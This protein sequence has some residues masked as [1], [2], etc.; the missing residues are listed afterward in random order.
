MS[1][2]VDSNDDVGSSCGGSFDPDS[3]D[4]PVLTPMRPILHI[5]TRQTFLDS[6]DSQ[7]AFTDDCPPTPTVEREFVWSPVKPFKLE[8]QDNMNGGETCGKRPFPDV[9]EEECTASSAKNT[10]ADS[11]VSNPEPNE[12]ETLLE[13]EAAD[14][15][16]GVGQ[17]VQSMVKDD[18]VTGVPYAVQ[19]ETQKEAEEANKEPLTADEETEKQAA[20]EPLTDVLFKKTLQY[21][22]ELNGEDDAVKDVMQ[23]II[24]KKSFVKTIYEKSKSTESTDELFWRAAKLLTV[25]GAHSIELG[26][27]KGNIT[28]QQLTPVQFGGIKG[29]VVSTCS[30]YYQTIGEYGERWVGDQIK[31]ENIP[32]EAP[33]KICKMSFPVSSTT[34]DY[35]FLTGQNDCPEDAPIR[36]EQGAIV[37]VGEVKTSAMNPSTRPIWMYEDVT[38][39]EIMNEK[40]AMIRTLFR[41]RQDEKNVKLTPA[42]MPMKLRDHGD[43]C[44]RIAAHAEESTRWSMWYYDDPEN[45]SVGRVEV[46]FDHKNPGNDGCIKLFSSS[47][48]RQMLCE[49]MSVLD[50]VDK[51]AKELEIRAF[52]PSVIDKNPPNPPK[53]R[54][55]KY[56][57]DNEDSTE[58]ADDE[59]EEEE[60]TD[61]PY[62]LTAFS[63]NCTMKVPIAD[64]RELDR[65]TNLYLAEAMYSVAKSRYLM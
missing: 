41:W 15:N 62:L 38:V 53:K 43:L 5:P 34:P 28:K 30:A 46:A 13:K 32:C 56:S 65:V 44:L 51:E 49:A 33:G 9:E 36:F 45:E 3:I 39:R 23:T 54:A 48:G 7:P 60:D 31:L 61:S 52:F 63:L 55:H 10:K 59:Y 50:Y 14:A 11:A 17:N 12:E 22:Q 1:R 18:G 21:I 37:G 26:N 47:I 58:E 40:P 25:G 27:T 57:W 8:R 64:L 2:A 29:A 35:I 16:Y 19:E 4:S 42:R 6:A 20:G 24:D